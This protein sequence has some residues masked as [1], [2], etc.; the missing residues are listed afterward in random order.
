MQLRIHLPLTFVVLL[1]LCSSVSVYA[2]DD[3]AKEIK[4][5][6]EMKSFKL[7]LVDAADKPVKGAK[8]TALGVRCEES[9]GSWIGWP[10][11]NAGNNEYVTD[12]NGAVEMKYP[13]KFGLPGQWMTTN[14]LDF[15]FKHSDY[16][17][18]RVEVD[19]IAET[20][21]HNLVQ[22]CR[23][24]FTCVDESGHAI[25]EFAVLMAGVGGDADWKL[26]DGE[27]RSS[28]VPDGKWQ[29]MLVSPSADGQHRFSRI[30]PARY[31][32]GK[33]VT[34]RE[35]PLRP[36]MRL[37]G[38][39]SDNVPRP[40]E[41][42]MVIAWCLPQPAG[43]T[44]GDENVSIGWS[45]ETAIAADGTFEFPALPPGGSI[46]LIA[47]CKGWLIR[48][49]EGQFTS[50]MEIKVDEAQLAENRVAGITLPM[51]AA[52]ELE[53]EV[54]GPDGMPLVG[55]DVST[56]PNQMLTKAGSQLLGVCVSTVSRMQTQITGIQA[57][58][59]DWNRPG[60][61]IQKTDEQGKVILREIPLRKAHQLFVSF[62]NLTANVD[63][64]ANSDPFE[65]AVDYQ[66]DTAERKKLTVHMVPI[67]EEA[68][69]GAQ[70]KSE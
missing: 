30:L 53:V 66:C 48:G 54:L 22:G 4:Y 33:D 17:A 12:D 40:V 7:S 61:Y 64:P 8:V 56:W 27:A 60:R 11:E 20:A 47:L 18:G 5:P 32:K 42:G 31:A 51:E 29:T 55:A 57:P 35:I 70:D 14:K 52:G 63:L 49:T 15:H 24:L 37:S 6:V 68:K 43:N 21:K 62:E 67:E 69:P 3:K 36:G 41:D 16:V 46:Q 25:N 13:V 58:E 2:E 45:E 9:P 39:L 1:C 44:Y 38:S 34:I 59:I 50:G 65:S 26:S 19:P 10:T 28:G 23:T